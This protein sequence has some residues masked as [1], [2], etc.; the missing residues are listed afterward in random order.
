M[1]SL[2]ETIDNA[3]ERRDLIDRYID[4]ELQYSCLFF[5]RQHVRVLPPRDNRVHE[6]LGLITIFARDHL[7]HWLEVLSYLDAISS[8]GANLQDLQAWL[9]AARIAAVDEID[10]ILE[11]VS[12]CLHL[13]HYFSSALSKG[14]WNAYRSCLPLCPRQSLLWRTYHGVNANS[15]DFRCG[16]LAGWGGLLMTL[17]G[18]SDAVRSVA[19]SPDGSRLASASRDKTVR[20]WDAEKGTPIGEALQGHSHWV[21]SVA[22]SP[23]GSRLASA[24]WDNTVRLWDAERG[25]PIGEALQGH[26]S[27]VR[28]VAFSP[29]GSSLAS[30]SDDM[31]I[32]PWDAEKGT[33][34]SELLLSLPDGYD[35]TSF[36]WFKEMMAL[37]LRSGRMIIIRVTV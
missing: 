21:R 37:G 10:E 33:P 27:S 35:L 11:L 6:I 19:F 29:D 14:P 18:H 24:S 20:L 23:D 15:L 5:S 28:S 1:Y 13:I 32:G 31:T 34:I 22:F 7:L 30:D 4:L 25:T 26:S 12:D 17:Q 3:T 16:Y 36:A 2:F 8:A 9:Q